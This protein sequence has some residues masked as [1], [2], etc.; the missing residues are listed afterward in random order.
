[1][2]HPLADQIR[3][4]LMRVRRVFPV[5]LA[6]R[7]TVSVLPGNRGESQATGRLRR[8]DSL[9]ERRR[10]GLQF[11]AP[12]ANLEVRAIFEQALA[13]FAPG[14]AVRLIDGHSQTAL[15]AADVVLVASGTATLEATLSKRPMVV[16]YR[17]HR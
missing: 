16:A 10:P 2:G 4:N 8:S 15:A 13:T 6:E 11:I 12:M 9:A 7:P 17:I 5:G 1:M 14:I 3:W